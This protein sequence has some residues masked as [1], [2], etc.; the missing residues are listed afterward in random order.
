MNKYKKVFFIFL[1]CLTV[2]FVMQTIISIPKYLHKT[3]HLEAHHKITYQD[4]AKNNFYVGKT[5]DLN[6][7]HVD[8]QFSRNNSKE[9]T[10]SDNNNHLY[11]VKLKDQYL[12]KEKLSLHCK[13]ESY[14]T[15][16]T[17]LGYKYHYPVLEKLDIIK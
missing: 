13:V 3:N 12:P 17:N 8:Q 2:L 6:N 11:F 14:R 4:L 9:A 15:L 16:K 5:Y 7:V 1:L 10:V